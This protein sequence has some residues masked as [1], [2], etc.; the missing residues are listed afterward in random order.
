MRGDELDSK[1]DMLDERNRAL[2]T[3]AIDLAMLRKI[4]EDL[5]QSNEYLYS[6]LAGIQHVDEIHIEIDIL[7]QSPQGLATLRERLFKM[8]LR[9]D[10]QT[11]RHEELTEKYKKV[12]VQILAMK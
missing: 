10:V 6:K 8:Q 2:R 4:H 11:K 3:L 7:S 1:L 9:Y 5:V 12:E